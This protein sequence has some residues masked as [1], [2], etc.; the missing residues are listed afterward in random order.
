MPVSASRTGKTFTASIRAADQAIASAAA[1]AQARTAAP[2][3]S[4]IDLPLVAAYPAGD[5]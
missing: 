5:R 2:S 4:S 1:A 3:S